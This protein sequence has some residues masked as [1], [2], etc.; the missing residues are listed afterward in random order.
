MH[1]VVALILEY[2]KKSMVESNN[3]PF[4]SKLQISNRIK[5]YV[6]NL[7]ISNLMKICLYILKDIHSL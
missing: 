7:N 4:A 1:K 6:I 2:I 5:L 3:S